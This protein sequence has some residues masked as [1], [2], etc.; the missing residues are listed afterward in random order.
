MDELNKLSELFAKIVASYDNN[1]QA[2]A[3][4][5]DAMNRLYA[6]CPPGLMKA[7]EKAQQTMAALSSLEINTAPLISLMRAEAVI[8]KEYPPIS[9][10]VAKALSALESAE[11]YLRD[12][13]SQPEES[14]AP[15]L[16]QQ[17]KPFREPFTRAE[18][19]QLL[20]LILMVISLLKPVPPEEASTSAADHTQTVI[21]QKQ[22]IVTPS[23][24][25]PH[26]KQDVVDRLEDAAFALAEELYA[27][28][29]ETEDV[30]D[31]VEGETQPK[32]DNGQDGD[33]KGED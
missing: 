33:A 25:S 27:F 1:A 15:E 2:L 21:I 9:P 5:V 26:D 24:Q 23:D 17:Y 18:L 31:P 29:D 8:S 19:W 4:T 14:E 11:P 32:A 20:S 28:G 10:A 13:P 22:I 6:E 30:E 7:L 16:P 3:S 12:V